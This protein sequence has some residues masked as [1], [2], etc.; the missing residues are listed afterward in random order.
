MPAVAIATRAARY[1]ILTIDLPGGETA[2]A[3][4]LLEDPASDRL[5]LRLRRDWER[6]APQEA[7]VLSELENDLRTQAEARGAAQVFEH[8]E[9]SLSNT[10]RISDRQST[11]ALDFEN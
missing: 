6:I 10:L 4:V 1:S 5:Y 7:E 3:G 11:M 9:T 8:L 2:N